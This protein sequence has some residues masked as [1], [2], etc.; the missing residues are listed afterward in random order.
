MSNETENSE[1]DADLDVL[2]MLRAPAPRDAEA[3]W[4]DF[5]AR[6][7]D[8][9]QD[10][11]APML[12]FP[13]RFIAAA[14]VIFVCVTATIMHNQSKKVTIGGVPVEPTESEEA[15]RTEIKSVNVLASHSG[16]LIMTDIESDAAILWIVDM[17]TNGSEDTKE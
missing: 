14:A 2:T 16:I 5:R 3:F 15:E 4:A 11:P 12:F 10:S 6:A 13:R 7:A 1:D 9:E 8:V 17:E